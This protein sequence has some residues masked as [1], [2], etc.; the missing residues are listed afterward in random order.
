MKFLDFYDF[1]VYW[2]QPKNKQ[3]IFSIGA[4]S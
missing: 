2:V 4:P 3:T 1:A